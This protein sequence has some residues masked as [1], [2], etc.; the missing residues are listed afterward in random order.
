MR[1]HSVIVRELLHY[2]WNSVAGLAAVT[3]AVGAIAAT[4]MLLGAYE[5]DA[6]GALH[7]K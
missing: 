1:L 4:A 3:L 2:R 6:A 5:A 7:A